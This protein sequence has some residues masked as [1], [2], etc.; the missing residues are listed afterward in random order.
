MKLKG[1]LSERKV[2][3]GGMFACWKK[4]KGHP[5]SKGNLHNKR[6]TISMPQTHNSGSRLQSEINNFFTSDKI[7][8]TL[9]LWRTADWGK[10]INFTQKDKYKTSFLCLSLISKLW[11]FRHKVFLNDAIQAGWRG[12]FWNFFLT[13]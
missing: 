6:I 5:L 13:Q 7:E 2:F 3:L 1:N 12:L 4:G 10:L 9:I 11:R 8:N